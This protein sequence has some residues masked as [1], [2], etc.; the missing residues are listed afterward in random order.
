MRCR[1]Y[2]KFGQATQKPEAIQRLMSNQLTLPVSVILQTKQVKQGPWSV[3]SWDAVGVIP[4]DPEAGVQ[5]KLLMRDGVDLQQYLWSGF[6]MHLYRDSAESY[7]YNLVGNNPSL[8]VLCHEAPDG[9]VEPFAVTAN[10]DEASAGIE[11]DDRVYSV[12]IPPEIYRQLEAFVVQHYV[13]RE[14]KVRKR[15]KWSDDKPS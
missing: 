15:K 8:Y 2:A 1:M 6:R 3:A 14:K 4:Y 5:R 13:P 7:W 11:G 9:G 10:H 12:P